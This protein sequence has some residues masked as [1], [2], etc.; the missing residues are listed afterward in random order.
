MSRPAPPPLARLAAGLAAALFHTALAADPALGQNEPGVAAGGTAPAVQV[1]LLTDPT[2]A[3]AAAQATGRPVLAI[4]GSSDCKTCV[5]LVKELT[6]PGEASLVAAEGYVVLVIDTENPRVW[7]VWQRTFKSDGEREPYVYVVR[8]DGTPVYADTGTGGDLAK[9]LKE[10]APLGGTAL[11]PERLAEMDQAAK[12]LRRLRKRDPAEFTRQLALFA[13]TGSYA[14]AARAVDA[15]AAEVEREVGAEILELQDRLR[16]PDL[17]PDERIDTAIEFTAIGREY[18]PLGGVKALYDDAHTTL[19]RESE[20]FGQMLDAAALLDA[21]QAAAAAK[22]WRTAVTNYEAVVE[23]FPGKSVADRAEAALPEAREKAA[24][25]PPA[26]DPTAT[27]ATVEGGEPAAPA[28]A[29]TEPANSTPAQSAPAKSTP[30]KSASADAERDARRAAST[31][32]LAKRYL[33]TNPEKAPE[34]LRRVIATA[35]D[36]DAAKEARELLGEDAP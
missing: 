30:A 8:A 16:R 13:G 21:A 35:P 27:V 24:A 28:P 25:M 5:D 31:L 20:S 6:E 19:G 1:R 7:G 3:M 34:Y 9:F 23:K 26:P 36:S 4:G 11:P 10:K 12:S 15:L 14:S 17:P 33:E 22:D 18:A 32:R 2:A 29:M